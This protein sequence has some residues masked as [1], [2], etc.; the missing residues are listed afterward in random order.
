V[1]KPVDVKALVAV[2]RNLE[3]PE[4]RERELRVAL[5]WPPSVVLVPI[6]VRYYMDFAEES[7]CIEL[8]TGRRCNPL[9]DPLV[10]AYFF[11]VNEKDRLKLV[12]I[13]TML[14]EESPSVEDM[15]RYAIAVSNGVYTIAFSARWDVVLTT[16]HIDLDVDRVVVIAYPERRVYRGEHAA[17]IAKIVAGVAAWR[18]RL[19]QIMDAVEKLMFDVALDLEFTKPPRITVNDAEVEKL[20]VPTDVAD[21]VVEFKSNDEVLRGAGVPP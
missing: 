10:R 14:R 7:N 3:R 20:L 5:S 21:A 1:A 18:L 13:D 8:P 6:P 16:P 4:R 9:E 15:G 12:V 17:A 11:L 19:H 2:G